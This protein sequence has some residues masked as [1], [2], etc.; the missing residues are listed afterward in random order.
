[1]LNLNCQYFHFGIDII[2]FMT[3]KEMSQSLFNARNQNFEIVRTFLFK[4]EKCTQ[5]FYL[6]HKEVVSYFYFSIG[7][8]L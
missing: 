8:F 4:K 7:P 3:I 2:Y 6:L 1:M 5:K